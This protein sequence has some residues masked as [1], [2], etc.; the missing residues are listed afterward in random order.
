MTLWVLEGNAGGIAFYERCG[1]ARTG[2]RM[3]SAYQDAP[4]VRYARTLARPDLP[5]EPRPHG[6]SVLPPTLDG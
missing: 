4:E 6:P 5:P 2:E 1:F 3:P